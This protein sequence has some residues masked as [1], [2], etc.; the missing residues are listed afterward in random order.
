MRS[1]IFGGSD[2]VEE[3]GSAGNQKIKI[4]THD[5]IEF[6][7]KKQR[8]IQRNNSHFN[9]IMSKMSECNMDE[10]SQKKNGEKNKK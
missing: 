7:Q 4:N 2:S 3:M 10:V 9:T 8:L 1:P 5:N 6:T